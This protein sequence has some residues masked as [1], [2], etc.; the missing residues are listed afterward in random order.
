LQS[1]TALHGLP[2]PLVAC[3]ELYLLHTRLSLEQDEFK[4]SSSKNIR[5]SIFRR[6]SDGEATRTSSVLYSVDK[7]SEKQTQDG[8]SNERREE[9]PENAQVDEIPSII[10]VDAVTR[11]KLM[12]K[13]HMRRASY[14]AAAVMISQQLCGINL[15]AFLA[16]TFFQNSLDPDSTDPGFNKKLLGLSAGFGV[17]NFLATLVAAPYIDA[18]KRGRRYLLNWSFPLM[19]VCMLISGTLLLAPHEG[20]PTNVVLAFHYIFLILFTIVSAS[21]VG[22]AKLTTVN[23]RTQLAKGQQRLSYHPRFSNR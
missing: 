14:A 5:N 9:L 3:G 20:K 12:A 8:P 16:D 18:P 23:R 11:W 4:K 7:L 6:K 19:A 21:D 13:P 2:S 1:L 15:L 17:V 10:E 22:V